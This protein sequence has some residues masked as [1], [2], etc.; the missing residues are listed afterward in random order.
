MFRIFYV[1]KALRSIQMQLK[2]KKFKIWIKKKRI[3]AARKVF[4]FFL[5]I[6]YKKAETRKQRHRR[7]LI[8]DSTFRILKGPSERS[9]EQ[10]ILLRIARRRIYK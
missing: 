5:K 3:E 9:E 7:N 10:N 2:A 4:G 8:P 1:A 6:L